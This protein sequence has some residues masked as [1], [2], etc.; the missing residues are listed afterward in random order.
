MCRVVYPGSQNCTVT[1]G[2]GFVG[3]RL[4]EMLVERGAERV[5]AFDIAPKPADASDDPR[6]VWMQGDLTSPSDVEKACRGSECVWHIAALVGPYHPLE[7]GHGSTLTPQVYR[8]IA[9]T[10]T[11]SPNLSLT[12]NHHTRLTRRIERSIVYNPLTSSAP[13]L[14]TSS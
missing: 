11:L 8:E 3:R 12:T 6:V 14:P 5:V 13:R 4:V 1:G 9:R 7:A 2:M 10:R